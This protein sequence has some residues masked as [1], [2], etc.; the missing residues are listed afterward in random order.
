MTVVFPVAIAVAAERMPKTYGAFHA[1][2]PSTTPYGSF[3]TIALCP[4]LATTG[5]LPQTLDIRP[6]ISRHMAIARGVTKN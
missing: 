6:A 1:T 2:T 5:T 3:Q 4:S